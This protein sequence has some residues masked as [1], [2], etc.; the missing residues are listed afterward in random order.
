MKQRYGILEWLSKII[1]EIYRSE[2]K[3]CIVGG[4]VNDYKMGK[5]RRERRCPYS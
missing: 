5:V 4:K 3:M 1:E 2:T